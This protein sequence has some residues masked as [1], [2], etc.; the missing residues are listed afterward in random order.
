MNEHDLRAILDA[1]GYHDPTPQEVRR[2]VVALRGYAAR[3]HPRILRSREL[4][5]ARALRCRDAHQ[6]NKATG[7]DELTDALDAIE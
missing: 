1:I 4:W 7:P 5:R 6:P 2:G 3:L